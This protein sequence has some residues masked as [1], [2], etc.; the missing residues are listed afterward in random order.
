[1]CT[2]VTAAIKMIGSIL[3]LVLLVTYTTAQG[4]PMIAVQ[5]HDLTVTT[6]NGD[7]RVRRDTFFCSQLIWTSHNCIASLNHF[8]THTHTHTHT[9]SLSLLM[10]FLFAYV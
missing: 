2:V 3:G 8:N 4:L 7:M 6:P 10:S 5:G 1:M 9:L